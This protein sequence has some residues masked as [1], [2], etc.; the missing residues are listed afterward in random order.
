MLPFCNGGAFK[1]FGLQDLGTPSNLK[2]ADSSTPFSYYN[3]IEDPVLR[4]EID[5]LPTSILL[6]SGGH[7]YEVFGWDAFN[8]TYDYGLKRSQWGCLMAVPF[9]NGVPVVGCGTVRLASTYLDNAN[10][11]ERDGTAYDVTLLMRIFHVVRRPV[12]TASAGPQ[13]SFGEVS[14]IVSF[15]LFPNFLAFVLGDPM[16]ALPM[17]SLEATPG[18]GM[19]RALTYDTSNPPTANRVYNTYVSD[20][21][22]SLD[23][24]NMLTGITGQLVEQC[25]NGT[26]ADGANAGTITVSVF[27]NA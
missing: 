14:V 13:N 4:V 27:D 24:T 17:L 1:V 21:S 7:D 12:I 2:S 9:S 3:P 19:K 25:V 11:V 15:C 23:A 8:G 6:T 5:S 20:N 26:C 10:A 22:F 16:P 18:A